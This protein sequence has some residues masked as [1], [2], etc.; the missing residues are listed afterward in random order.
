[1][2]SLCYIVFIFFLYSVIGLNFDFLALNF[3]GFIA[4]S[5]FNVG[6]FWVPYVKE[7]FLKRSPNGVNPVE[8]N[9]V[10][11]SL[12]AVVLTLVGICQ[13]CL[14][15]R[16]EQRVSKVAIGL[17]VIAWVFAFSALFAAVTG[18]ITWLD[19][20]YYFS[21]IKL[22]VTLV[23]YIPQAYMNYRRKSTVG[24]S[25]GNVLLDFT[26]RSF[27]LI[28]M[29]LQSFNNDQWMLI[30]GDLTKFGLGVFSILFDILFITQHCCLYSQKTD[31]YQPLD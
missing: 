7:E 26:G 22:G 6:M 28:Q 23:K 18:T 25:I 24:W 21:Y 4:Y 15:E 3:T 8:A 19:Y 17:L 30:F 27:S 1:M 2:H 14:Y 29:F 12:H 31:A 13:C 5:M 20:L 11:F 10:F 16:G 9:D